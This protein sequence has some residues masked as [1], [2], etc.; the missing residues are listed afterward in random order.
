MSKKQQTKPG[1]LNIKPFKWNSGGTYEERQAMLNEIAEMLDW[2]QHV[3]TNPGSWPLL[4]QEQSWFLKK[5]CLAGRSIVDSPAYRW[6]KFE[7]A[8][9]RATTSNKP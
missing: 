6:F 2:I 1:N 3:T 4:P 5:T 8:T 9:E 7:L